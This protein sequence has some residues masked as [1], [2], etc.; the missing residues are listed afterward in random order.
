MPHTFDRRVAAACLALA[1]NTV[2]LAGPLSGQTLAGSGRALQPAVASVGPGIEFR[3]SLIT[4]V[5]FNFDENGLLV[6]QAGNRSTLS[7]GIYTFSD[8]NGTIADIVGFRF[9]NQEFSAGIDQSRL[10][11]TADS[12]SIDLRSGILFRASMQIDFA[13]PQA[14]PEPGSMG[15]ALA[16]VGGL[17]LVGRRR[18]AQARWRGQRGQRPG[19]PAGRSAHGHGH[20]LQAHDV[21]HHH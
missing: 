15:L 18:Q 19:L 20:D 3:Y 11:F 13:E 12:V 2:A 7:D 8:L 21:A 9:L 14:V 6:V 4:T 5:G 1:A 17:A 10:S 16:A